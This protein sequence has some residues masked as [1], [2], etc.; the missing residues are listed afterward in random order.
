MYLSRLLAVSFLISV[1]VTP[2]AAQRI[3]GETY[4]FCVSEEPEALPVANDYSVPAPAPFQ[5]LPTS[6][7]KI[8]LARVIPPPEFRVTNVRVADA[9]G[10]A[11]P[12]FGWE[13]CV[14]GYPDERGRFH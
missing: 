8:N 6:L 5:R 3:I 7:N 11:L 12:T 13:R 9:S 2:F 10:V 14:Y 1:C 4:R